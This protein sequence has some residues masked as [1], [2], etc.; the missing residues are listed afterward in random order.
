MAFTQPI[1]EE[2]PHRPCASMPSPALSWSTAV[3]VCLCCPSLSPE[4]PSSSPSFLWTYGCA[5]ERDRQ[6]VR[7]NHQSSVIDIVEVV[8]RPHWP[9]A[10]PRSPT[11]RSGQRRPCMARE[12]EHMHGML[13]LIVEVTS[14][15]A[16]VL[17]SACICPSPTVA[18]SA[19][20]A[21]YVAPPTPL[22]SLLLL[23][24]EQVGT[25]GFGC[26]SWLGR[27]GKGVASEEK[28]VAGYG[29]SQRWESRCLEGKEVFWVLFSCSPL[30]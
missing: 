8:A 25:L 28:R 19:I 17:V 27:T 10:L 21:A 12:L 29:T 14:A 1:S 4:F 26:G 24:L 22:P 20:L 7:E 2:P 6:R 23:H 9:P 3:G 16:V 13:N 11:S 18:R 15:T 5:W 30:G